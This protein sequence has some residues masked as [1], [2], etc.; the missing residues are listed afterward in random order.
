MFPKIKFLCLLFIFA[1]SAIMLIPLNVFIIKVLDRTIFFE[2]ISNKTIVSI[3]HINSI[4]N[5]KV[6]EVFKINGK[7]FE[8]IDVVTDSYGVK[9]YY[10][11]TE[12]VAKRSL[13]KMVFF[14]GQNRNFVLRVN[15]KEVK[16]INKFKEKEITLRIEEMP[17][18]KFLLLMLT[19]EYEK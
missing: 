1:I 10:G 9:E 3:S 6:E 16:E 7:N 11:I 8:L 12:G 15:N 18:F 5:A 19:L 2:K 14:N 17:I 4:Y 13:S